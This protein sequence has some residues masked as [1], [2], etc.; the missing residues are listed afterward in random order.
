MTTE[1]LTWLAIGAAPTVALWWLWRQSGRAQRTDWGH[2]LLNR[3]DGFNRLFCRWYHG[4]RGDTLALPQTGGGIVVA[5]HISGLDP[6]LMIARSTRPLRFLIAREQ[7]DRWWLHWLF[8]AIGCIPVERATRPQAALRAARDALRAGEVIALFPHGTIVTRRKA[9][10]RIKRGAAWLARQLDMPVYPVFLSGVTAAG[11]TVLA[12]AV[13][14][15]AKLICKLPIDPAGSD[16]SEL[17]EK[18][19]SAIKA[20][21]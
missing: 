21:S 11:L 6:L 1:M 12:V 16:E 18:I 14:G 9:R 20:V 5:N 4:L 7:Y 10:P 17:M 15:R 19:E 13:P 2:P 3:L 8:K